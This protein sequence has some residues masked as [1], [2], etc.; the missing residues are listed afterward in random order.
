MPPCTVFNTNGG[1]LYLRIRIHTCLCDA[2]AAYTGTGGY[3]LGVQLV[4]SHPNRW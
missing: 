1:Y 4:N 2:H 3:D